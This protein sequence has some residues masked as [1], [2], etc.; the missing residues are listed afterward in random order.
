M[1]ERDVDDASDVVSLSDATLP[2][3]HRNLNN[4]YKLR[5]T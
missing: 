3:Q 1:T 4:I 5:G 2:W